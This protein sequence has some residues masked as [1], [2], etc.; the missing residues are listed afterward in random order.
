MP[1]GKRE[2][3]I[4]LDEYR[5]SVHGLAFED[6]GIALRAA[7][8]GIVPTTFK[9]PFSDEDIDIRVMLP[10]S[11]R[12]S[13]DDLLDL[14]LRTPEQ[15]LVKL[16]DVSTVAIRR[17]FQRLYHYDG[18][19]ALVVYADVD[20]DKTT[21]VL[22]NQRLAARFADIPSRFPG[23]SLVLGGEYEE[24]NRAFEDMGRA[25]VIAL[26]AIYAILAAQFRSYLQ[27]LIVMCVI[28]F[29]Y[30]GVVI[31][32]YVWDYALS[33]YVIYAVV[34]LAGVVVNDSLVLI[35]FV[36]R[37][38]ERGT[39]SER[40]VLIAGQKRFRA[41][42]LTTLTTVAGLLPMAMGISGVSVVFG[43]FAAAIV[44]GL[45]VASGLTLFVVPTLYLGIENLQA[46]L[47]SRRRTGTPGLDQAGAAQP[48]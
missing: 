28:V 43:P 14:D 35:D 18:Q 34:G 6:L 1:L 5:A 44:V 17:G 24:T 8:D 42:M 22:V 26:I 25:F 40:A 10:E 31:G 41:V 7:N 38:R 4:G 23:A 33:M 45:S 37:E 11:Q 2:L 27:P 36:N 19:R 39:P 20:P 47:A 46:R 9:D 15:Y 32:M 3:Q 21:S 12:R 16:G 29:A 13:A 30:V 48:S